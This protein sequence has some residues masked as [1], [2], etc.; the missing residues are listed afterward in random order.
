LLRGIYIV[1]FWY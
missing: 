1:H